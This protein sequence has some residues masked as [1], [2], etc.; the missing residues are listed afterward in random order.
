MAW[1]AWKSCCKKV[2]SQCEHFTGIH[3]R[4][5]R[6]PVYRESQL[7]IGWSEQKCK[8]WNELAKQAHTNK[9]TPE[10]QRRYKG[11]W[12][13]T[14][15]KPGK[16]GPMKLRSDFRA[17][18]TIKNRLHRESGEQ[19]EEPISPGK[20]RRIQQGQEVFSEDGSFTQSR[21]KVANVHVLTMVCFIL[22]ALIQSSSPAHSAAILSQTFPRLCHHHL[23]FHLVW[24]SGSSFIIF[25]CKEHH[26]LVL[27][28]LLTF[29]RYQLPHWIF[30]RRP[31]PLLAM[32]FLQSLRTERV[33]TSVFISS[34]PSC[35]SLHNSH[36]MFLLF[37]LSKRKRRS[38][39]LVFHPLILSK[40]C[41]VQDQFSLP[42]EKTAWTWCTNSTLDLPRDILAFVHQNIFPEAFIRRLNSFFNG[43]VWCPLPI[44]C[45]AQ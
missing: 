45:I 17:A 9:L 29:S 1:N 18:V 28:H 36:P 25:G 12:Y 39:V 30:H 7:E 10:E 21:A 40:V 23:C 13:L 27:L 4:F 8:E 42:K 6:D 15:N 3:D 24:L 32:C 34:W 35:M 43:V 14:L 19:E 11:H 22:R 20:Q 37:C 38:I 41:V 16:N 26:H 31:I 33:R 5:L 2:D 44:H